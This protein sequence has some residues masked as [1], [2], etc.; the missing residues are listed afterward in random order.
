[1]TLCSCRNTTTRTFIRDRKTDIERALKA[2]RNGYN[3]PT[4]G[5]RRDIAQIEIE[6]KWK[7]L[8]KKETEA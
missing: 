5:E 8:R 4:L 3:T 7:F 6:L 2:R 1:M